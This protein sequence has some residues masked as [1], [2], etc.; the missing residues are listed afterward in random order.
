[1]KKDLI[2]VVGVV[3]KIFAFNVRIVISV[4]NSTYFSGLGSPCFY[5][6]RVYNHYL[7][8][9]SCRVVD[10]TLAT[11]F[12]FLYLGVRMLDFY[13]YQKHFEE[14]ERKGVAQSEYAY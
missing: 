6:E 3:E 8:R 5:L 2:L 9:A 12:N 13:I 11:Y 14:K 7:C 10:R 4:L 1:M